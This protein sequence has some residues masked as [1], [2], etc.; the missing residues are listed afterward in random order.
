MF[1]SNI[2]R[3][4]ELKN[5]TLQNAMF[6]VA[7]G[8][9]FLVLFDL[10]GGWVTLAMIGSNTWQWYKWA[11]FAFCGIFCLL[12]LGFLGAFIVTAIK[13]A[14]NKREVDEN[15]EIIPMPT[16]NN[17][18]KIAKEIGAYRKEKTDLINFFKNLSDDDKNDNKSQ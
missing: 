5:F 10:S 8:S 13:W 11:N 18:D 4:R 12:S 1:E 3:I 14:C 7:M 17:L 6:H 2:R 9:L 15:N 16:P